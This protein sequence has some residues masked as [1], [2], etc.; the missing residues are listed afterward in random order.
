MNSSNDIAEMY[1][2]ISDRFDRDKCFILN[3]Y[4]SELNQV[5]GVKE[6]KETILGTF[7]DRI[8]A[9]KFQKELPIIFEKSE[10]KSKIVDILSILK[11]D[12]EDI[13]NAIDLFYNIPVSAI[14]PERADKVSGSDDAKRYMNSNSGKRIKQI[15]PKKD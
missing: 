5:I 4:P 10:I 15:F 2:K 3:S 1:D 7:A 14:L 6:S 12:S 9:R 8:S 13:E 11:A